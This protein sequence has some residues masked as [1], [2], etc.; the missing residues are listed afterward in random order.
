LLLWSNKIQS[1]SE[2][3]KQTDLA[4]NLIIRQFAYWL[5]GKEKR[6]PPKI[7]GK[8]TKIGSRLEINRPN[9]EKTE[10]IINKQKYCMVGK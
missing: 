2:K 3:R 7:I 1:A 9:T 6:N 5:V 4:Q 10:L 8:K